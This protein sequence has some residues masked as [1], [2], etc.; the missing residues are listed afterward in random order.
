MST[1][2][3]KIE[4][5]VYQGY[6]LAHHQGE[7]YFVSNALPDDL[8]E[9]KILYSKKKVFFCEISNVLEKSPY[10]SDTRCDLTNDCGACDWVN[11]DYP[12]QL[13]LKGMIYNDIIKS[14]H[15]GKLFLVESVQRDQYRNKVTFP[16]QK[17]GDT[18]KIGMYQ[19][20]THSVVEHNHCFLYPQIFKKILDT[21][22]DWMIR[23]HIEPY[24][25]TTFRGNLRYI[26]LR[27]SADLKSILVI[28]ITKQRKLG[29]TN[30]LKNSLLENF[31]EI[32]G[33][34]QNIQKQP[35]NV[36]FG[37]S[38]K[39]IYGD[40]FYEER[41]A[42]YKCNIH[43]KAFFQVNPPQAER[44]YND[45]ANLLNAN[46]IVIDAYSGIG[47]MGLFAADKCKKVYCIEEN[48][49]AVKSAIENAKINNIKN[50]EFIKDLTEKCLSALTAE[51]QIDTIIF[52]PPR[53]GLDKSI[54]EALTVPK[55]IY[56]SCDPVTQKRDIDLL[57][58]KGY[59]LISLK[60]YD[61]F[62]HTWHIE[63][64]AVLVKEDD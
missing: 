9:A 10:R 61:M 6:G 3:L 47:S 22:K 13:K 8:V 29:F 48:E 37:E 16:V 15:L 27:C 1:I 11:V 50:I 45:I 31:P 36:N 62:P 28:L 30:Q 46:D 43:Y 44:I 54:I 4:K 17:I 19:R 64:L 20:Q 24:D 59:T 35:N 26:C 60:A 21:V 23:A 58:A 33:I 2:T 63:S 5:V 12:N 56:L 52:D 57:V 49:E 55:I 40:D 34:I 42:R 18:I 32:K 53:K 39:L 25:E 14:Y 7:Q 51:N 38:S 41:L